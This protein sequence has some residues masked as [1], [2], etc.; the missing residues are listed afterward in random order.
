MASFKSILTHL[1]SCANITF[2]S[3]VEHHVKFAT[4]SKVKWAREYQELKRGE[5]MFKKLTLVLTAFFSCMLISCN[6]KTIVF[7]GRERTYALH[8]P[9]GY[10]GETAV[11]IV[12]D[13]HPV[14]TN[15]AIMESMSNFRSKSDEEGF[16]LVQ[17]NGI[18]GSWNGGPA[19]CGIS[20]AQDADDV[21]LMRAILD[22]VS[23]EYSVDRQRVY[24]DGMSNGGYLAHKVACEAADITAAIGGV[25]SNLGY[26]DYDECMPTR[27]IPVVMITGGADRTDRTETFLRWLEINECSESF[28]VEEFGVFT[29][30]T[31]NECKDGVATT[32]CIGEG[33][34]HC[35][36]GTSFPLWPCSMDLDATDYL[37]EFFSKYSIP[38]L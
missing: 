18:N 1:K 22:Q 35:W 19:C 14:A 12:F 36:P 13:L 16:I 25:V 11:P 37:W 29:C 21:G 30:T 3:D 8:I 24:F 28:I 38:S 33:V 9:E 20:A 15:A 32:H 10:D 23:E 2:I 34:G 5:F 26:D 6:Q 17:P 31:Y 7:E 4:E 27:P